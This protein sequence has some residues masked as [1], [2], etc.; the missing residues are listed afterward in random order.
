MEIKNMSKLAAVIKL[1]AITAGI[2]LIPTGIGALFGVAGLVIGGGIG[3][4]TAAAFKPKK[5]ICDVKP[6]EIVATYSG[7]NLK[8]VSTGVAIKW[9]L[10]HFKVIPTYT[11]TIKTA[12]VEVSTLEG[13][14]IKLD[15]EYQCKII[16]VKKYEENFK[17]QQPMIETEIR[18]LIGSFMSKQTWKTSEQPELKNNCINYIRKEIENLTFDSGV[19]IKTLSIGDIIL[20]DDI[21]NANNKN[22]ESQIELERTITDQKRIQTEI[23]FWRKNGC[24]QDQIMTILQRY[25]IEKLND[26]GNQGNN[27]TVA[28]FGTNPNS[29]ITDSLLGTKMALQSEQQKRVNDNND[30]SYTK[31]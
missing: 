1:A 29:Q 21:V 23:D 30:Q 2:I 31:K 11:T 5:R 14:Q 6:D 3:L 28:Q 16:D 18:G 27:F 15:F 19:T 24:S 4:I 22:T 10:Q 26:A 7:G 17:A 20:P 25:N 12:P 13:I 9:P 8:K